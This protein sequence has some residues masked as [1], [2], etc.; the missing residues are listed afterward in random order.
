VFQGKA[1]KLQSYDIIDYLNLVQISHLGGRGRTIVIR[2]S[3]SPDLTYVFKG[4]NFR[5]FLESR[6]NFKQRK[7]VYYYKIRIICSLPKYQNIM[8]SPNI[9]VTTRKIDDD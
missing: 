3:S 7:R 5:S 9:L 1:A 8:P 2:S 4:V 6:A